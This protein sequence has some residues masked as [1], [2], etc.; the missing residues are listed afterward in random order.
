MQK[1]MLCISVLCVC[2]AAQVSRRS[3]HN[4]RTGDLAADIT[5]RKLNLNNAS[6]LSPADRQKIIADIKNRKYEHSGLEQISERIRRA[7]QEQGYFKAEVD[8]SPAIDS[9]RQ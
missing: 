5:I 1:F 8:S 3:T 9:I 6:K 2:A 4:P 7:Y